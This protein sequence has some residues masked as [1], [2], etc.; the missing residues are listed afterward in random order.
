MNRSFDKPIQ[1]GESRVR[2]TVKV[3]DD[4]STD[5]TRLVK[6]LQ[7]FVDAPALLQCGPGM[8]QK[9]AIF[10]NGSAWQMVGEAEF[11]S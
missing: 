5:P 10:H 7:E 8:V 9:F 6:F 3:T 4:P 11:A 2:H 1:I